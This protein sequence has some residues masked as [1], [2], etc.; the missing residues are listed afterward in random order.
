MYVVLEIVIQLYTSH[1]TLMV[2]SDTKFTA[3]DWLDEFDWDDLR[4]L[5]GFSGRWFDEVKGELNVQSEGYVGL[6]KEKFNSNKIRKDALAYWLE[7]ASDIMQRQMHVITTFKGIIDVMKTEAIADKTKVVKVQEKLLECQNDQ[8]G[9][10]KSAVEST[11]H[12]TVQEEIRSYSDVVSKS[13]TE[14]TTIQ[15]EKSLRKV[16]KSAIEEE[17]RSKN[18]VIFCLE[19]SDQERIDTK[20]ATLFSELGEKPRVSASRIGRK[21]IDTMG[22]HVR[23]VRVTLASST[24]VHQVLTKARQLK[25]VESFK[26]VYICPDRS[27]E[28]RAARRTLVMELK[29]AAAKQPDYKHYIKNGKVHSER[30]D[31]E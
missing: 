9:Q 4:D 28:E 19:E 23:P 30:K 29:S 2:Q 16:V 5:E 10:L 31:S 24:A 17:D 13:R 15:N 27:P 25:L 18:L 20:V 26:S 14:S 11:V 3:A 6:T 1:C 22:D 8:L 7:E 12:S 21:R